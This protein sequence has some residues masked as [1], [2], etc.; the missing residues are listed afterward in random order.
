[1]RIKTKNGLADNLEKIVGLRFF[2]DGVAA[3]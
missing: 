3:S 2:S 1:L